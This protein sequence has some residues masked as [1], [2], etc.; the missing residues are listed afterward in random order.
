MHWGEHFVGNFRK[1]PMCGC[2]CDLFRWFFFLANDWQSEVFR[3]TINHSIEESKCLML[4]SLMIHRMYGMLIVILWFDFTH[5]TRKKKKEKN[6]QQIRL[7]KVPFSH[8]YGTLL[9]EINAKLLAL[10]MTNFLAVF[11]LTSWSQISLSFRLTI[12]RSSIYAIIHPGNKY[13]INRQ[14][15]INRNESSNQI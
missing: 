14:K 12:L 6:I 11:S 4:S 8:S 13:E 2:Q 1:T 15:K 9:S 7:I 3:A 10:S 5:F